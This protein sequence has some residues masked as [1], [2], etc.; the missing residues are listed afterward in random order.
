MR[1]VHGL[2]GVAGGHRIL[3]GGRRGQ[4]TVPPN[5]VSGAFRLNGTV[6][7]WTSIERTTWKSKAGR[8]RARPTSCT[9]MRSWPR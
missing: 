2:A 1:R 5:G 9:R 7:S 6:A 4:P 8:E 3:A